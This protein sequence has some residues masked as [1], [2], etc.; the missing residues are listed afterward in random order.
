MVLIDLIIPI[1]LVHVPITECVAVYAI[2]S[3]NV[4]FIIIAQ[5]RLVLLQT[6]IGFT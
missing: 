3:E 5:C 6:A 1:A 2:D 4:I